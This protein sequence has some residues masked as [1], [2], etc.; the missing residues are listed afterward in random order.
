[1]GRIYASTVEYQ[2]AIELDLLIR[3]GDVTAWIPQVKVQLGEDFKTTV[4]FLV[5]SHRSAPD[6]LSWS[7]AW[8]EEVKGV[9]MPS[10]RTVRRLWIK[11]G[12]CAMKIL[13]RKGSGW[14]A[15]WLEPNRKD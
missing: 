3:S 14:R 11:Y 1:M 8:F 4:D 13:K 9:E 2:R 12:P 6:G 7:A 5:F 10:F 15:E